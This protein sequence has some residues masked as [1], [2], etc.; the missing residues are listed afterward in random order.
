MLCVY[1][2][3]DLACSIDLSMSNYAIMIWRDD[4][5]HISLCQ[6]AHSMMNTRMRQNGTSS[7]MKLIFQKPVTQ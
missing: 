6:V 2:S 1:E 4:V 7:E 3:W 5:D